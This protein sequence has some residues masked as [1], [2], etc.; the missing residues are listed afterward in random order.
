M[1]MT[2]RTTAMHTCTVGVGVAM[3]FLVE[4]MDYDFIININWGSKSVVLLINS[5]LLVEEFVEV[6]NKCFTLFT[7]VGGRG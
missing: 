4:I 7:Y 3:A 6:G 2:I 1:V 5:D